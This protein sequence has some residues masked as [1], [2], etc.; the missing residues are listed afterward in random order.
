MKRVMDS[1]YYLQGVDLE[2]EIMEKSIAVAERMMTVFT[3]EQNRKESNVNLDL[4]KLADKIVEKLKREGFGR[5][6][7]KVLP[8]IEKKNSSF[9][10][11]DEP[12][13]VS[14]EKFEIKGK[15]GTKTKSK[16]STSG[17]LDA[18]MGL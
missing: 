10:F 15:T 8:E 1:K 2:K 12:D 13:I 16:E 7:G 11:D 18:L 4:D 6:A 14:T 17:A 3:R 5:V 9:S